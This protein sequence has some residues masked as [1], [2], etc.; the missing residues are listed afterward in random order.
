MLDCPEVK[1]KELASK[2]TR[3]SVEREE[4]YAKGILAHSC[5]SG[6]YVFFVTAMKG[7]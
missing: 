1:R 3:R 5:V 7:R 6:L 2:S 4:D